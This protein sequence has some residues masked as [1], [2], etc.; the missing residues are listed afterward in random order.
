M[1]GSMLR[2]LAVGLVA[3]AAL[4]STSTLKLD[5]KKERRSSLMK[6]G[7]GYLNVPLVEDPN[8]LSYY[9]NI[10]IGTPPQVKLTHENFGDLANISQPFTVT[11][12]TGSSDL[13]VPNAEACS[14]PEQQEGCA[15]G[16]V[17]QPG[18]SSTYKALSD[19]PVILPYGIGGARGILSSDTVYVEGVGIQNQTL[20]AVSRVSDQQGIGIL[21][22]GY[23]AGE[24]LAA[25]SGAT[26]PTVVD[27]LFNQGAINRRAFSLYLDDQ[28]ANTGSIIFGGIDHSKYTGDLVSLA[29]TP[30]STGNYDRYA[31]DLSSV[32]FI[33]ESGHHLLTSPHAATRVTLD[34]GSTLSY[35]PQNVTSAIITGLGAVYV[36]AAQV[37]VAPCVYR[38]ASASLAFQFGGSNGPTIAVKLSQLLG[39]YF[40]GDLF[41]DGNE[42]CTVNIGS[43]SKMETNALDTVILGDSFLR[44]AY[45]VYDLDNN[46]IS[47]AQAKF[48][49]TGTSNIQA[50]PSGSGLPGVS[51]TA[52]QLATQFPFPSSLRTQTPTGGAL[53]ATASGASGAETETALPAS[54]SS[55]TFSLGVATTSSGAAASNSPAPGAAV[56]ANE[57]GGAIGLLVGC[58]LTAIFGGMVVL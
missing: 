16:G 18:L 2:P 35:L 17:Y 27:A 38:T 33:D 32:T 24:V 9:A 49:Q 53:T 29:I 58:T 5:F 1:T 40:S 23:P 6:R 43:L 45:A 31:I 12:D 57:L 52:T 41:D 3:F 36:P 13:W 46:E 4:A 28:E 39:D 14:H 10:S 26:Y 22:I 20:Y 15:V 42:A 34:S 54:A 44:S 7:N 48:D 47:L 37:Y 25:E 19:Q 56:R 11:L 8:E 50:I 55:P 30:N 51:S 21:G